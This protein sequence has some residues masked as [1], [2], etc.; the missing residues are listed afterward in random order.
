MQS[1]LNSHGITVYVLVFA[2]LLLGPW[3]QVAMPDYGL[4]RSG[5]NDGQYWRFL[6]G[7]LVHASW[8]HLALNMAGLLLLQQ[9]FGA[10]LRAVV[11][12]WAYV[13]IGITVG[14]CL[15][16]FSRFGSV[17]GFSG[18]LHG[19]FACAACLALKRDPLLAAGVLLLLV[20]KVG[21][22]QMAGGSALMA[23]LIGMPV[24]TD[25]HLYGALGG[26]VLGSV[27][28]APGRASGKKKPRGD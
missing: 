15:L 3:N 10:E 27:M 5:L 11:L 17:Y 22:E 24:A 4:L 16:A 9:I 8:V 25:A 12:V 19:L 13:V 26:A 28:A 20:A 18:M 23:E 7:P 2:C 6:T 1:P 21:W 14:I